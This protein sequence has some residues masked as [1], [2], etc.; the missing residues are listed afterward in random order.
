MVEFVDG[1]LAEAARRGRWQ[2]DLRP[3]ER[4][5][6]KDSHPPSRSR[7]ASRTWDRMV[8]H[9]GEFRTVT[10]DFAGHGRSD[11]ADEYSVDSLLT[12]LRTVVSQ[13]DIEG[14]YVIVGHS[15]GADLSL[16]HA[17]DADECRGAV[18][19]DGAFNVSPPETDWE[20]F[21]IME[22]RF[23][24][25]T[26]MSLGRVMGAAPSM[27]IQEIRSLTEDLESRRPQFEKYLEGLRVP[28]VFVV[29]E[30]ADKVPDGKLIHER[31]MRAVSEIES[32]YDV[33]VEY[34]PCGHFVP[35]KEPKRLADLVRQFSA[36]VFA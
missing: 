29:G 2:K 19:V 18:L 21:S 17:S 14:G 31:K 26:F 28:V 20:R 34:L 10:F 24:F 3:R 7:R 35:M 13:V 8:K 4:P 16:L 12:D 11:P 15:I 36:S 32:R 1:R 27:S 9:L 33:A 6:R 22:D 30:Q 23:L 25:K 5:A